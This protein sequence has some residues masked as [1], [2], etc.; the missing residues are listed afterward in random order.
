MEPDT[1]DDFIRARFNPCEASLNIIKLKISLN[2]PF[3]LNFNLISNQLWREIY[4][5]FFITDRIA[6]KVMF[7]HLSLSHSVHSG[8][9]V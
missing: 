5:W 4:W 6:G 2:N 7:V 9:V 3:G 8:G 1:S